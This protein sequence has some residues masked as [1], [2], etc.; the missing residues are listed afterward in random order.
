M[1]LAYGL[2]VM[3]LC[4]CEFDVLKLVQCVLRTAELGETIPNS[5]F[6][7]GNN[8][9]LLTVLMKNGIEIF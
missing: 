9:W 2:K 4:K 8:T 3:L 6:T 1:V 5:I 7:N